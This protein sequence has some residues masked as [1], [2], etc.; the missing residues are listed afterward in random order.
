[1]PMD[2]EGSDLYFL[3]DR[4]GSMAGEKWAKTADALIAFAKA[5]TQQ[6]RIWITF[7]ESDYRDFAEKPLWRD[8]LL[9]DPNFRSLAKLGTGG[10][11]N[12]FPRYAMSLEFINDFHPRAAAISFSSRTAKSPT[13]KLF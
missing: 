3:V 7:F 6:D 5:T 1:V 10:A 2:R 12:Y 13:R 4:S 9:R 8:A 11:P